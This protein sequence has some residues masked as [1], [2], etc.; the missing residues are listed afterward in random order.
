MEVVNLTKLHACLP[1]RLRPH[2]AQSFVTPSPPSP[3]SQQM[4]GDKWLTIE[5][6]LALL[7]DCDMLASMSLDR[8]ATAA[9]Q[10]Q[11]PEQGA[12]PVAWSYQRF[13]HFG[14]EPGPRWHNCLADEMPISAWQ[15]RNLRP[16]VFGDAT[17]PA[18]KLEPLNGMTKEAAKA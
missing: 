15:T 16:L 8:A 6:V 13:M 12:A 11:A 17:P 18:P 3:T 14:D 10:P 1:Q 4:N 5:A 7:N 2:Y 9:G